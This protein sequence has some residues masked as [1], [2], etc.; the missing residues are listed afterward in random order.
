MDC[1]DIKFP[2]K[3]IIGFVIAI[4]FSIIV[5][6]PS[7]AFWWMG[8][9]KPAFKGKVIDAETK[10]PI[11]GAVVVVVYS[12]KSI[13]IA[14]SYSVTI[15]VRET[16]TDKNG[17]FY[18]P[19]YTTIIQPLSWE[20]W[21]SF[22]IF[23]PG[24]GS[25]PNW[26]VYPPM[27]LSLSVLED[28]FSGEVGKEGEIVERSQI[29]SLKGEI[30]DRWKVTFGVVELPKLKTRDERIKAKPAPVGAPSDWKKQKEFIKLIRQEWQ[31]LTGEDP[32]DL[33]INK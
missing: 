13:G 17:E 23:K 16:L 6:T 5:A 32:G 18:I 12:K 24:Y 1:K 4:V 29:P 31:Y 30:L 8:Y 21:A 22:I 10:E 27:N 11:E 26:R 19:S 25:F 7:H 20:E 33:Y 9:H 2:I 28:F 14:E 15:N 3:L